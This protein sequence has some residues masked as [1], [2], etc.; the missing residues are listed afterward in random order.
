M[1]E[2]AAGVAFLSVFPVVGTDLDLVQAT[3]ARCKASRIAYYDS[4]MTEAALRT[5]ASILYT[6]DMHHGT[7]Y[8]PLELRNPFL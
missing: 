4:L 3:V 7:R 6:E 2:A 1:A 8:D 5:G